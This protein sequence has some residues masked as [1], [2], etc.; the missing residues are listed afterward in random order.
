[1]KLKKICK[2]EGSVKVVTGLAIKGASNELNIGGADSEVVKNPLT[3]E[4]Y[5]PGSSLKGKMRSQLEKVYG[6]KNK[7]G[8]PE[9]G[10]PC[11]CGGKT[12][13]VC[14]L[15]GAHMNPGAESAPTRI[16]VRD[17]ELTEDSRTKI[18]D[19]PVE[20]GGYLEVKAENLIKRDK[21]IVEAPRFMERV[22]AGLEFHLEILVQVFDEDPEEQLRAAVEKA[23]EMVE[24]SYLGG[25]GSRGYGQVQFRGEWKEIGVG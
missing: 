23:L 13:M 20:R 2:Y 12:C 25:S 21:G 4:P 24:L 22:P 14:T 8:K 11:G 5:I 15:F 6:M 1:M 3:G 9:E 16:I 18:Q 10:K 17:C 7:Y 19:M